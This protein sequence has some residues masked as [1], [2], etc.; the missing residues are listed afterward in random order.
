MINYFENLIKNIIIEHDC[1][2][3]K[4]IIIVKE[5]LSLL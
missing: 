2:S 5:T 4:N 3:G 1:K